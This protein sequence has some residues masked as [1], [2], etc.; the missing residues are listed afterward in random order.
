M[1]SCNS[2][3]QEAILNQNVQFLK[4]MTM[5]KHLVGFVCKLPLYYVMPPKEKELFSSSFYFFRV[6]QLEDLRSTC[7]QPQ[8][9]SLMSKS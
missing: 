3:L 5:Q 2:C 7:A 6:G 9:P 1:L 8:P 4:M